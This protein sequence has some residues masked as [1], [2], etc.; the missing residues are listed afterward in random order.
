MPVTSLVWFRNDLRVT[1]HAPLLVAARAGVVV[2]VF[3]ADP[4]VARHPEAS[5]ARTAF[6][7]GCVAALDHE[8][9]ALGGR[10]IRRSGDPLSELMALIR[11]TGASALH[12]HEGIDRL[13][14]RVRD[15]RVHTALTGFGVRCHW[16]PAP[17]S[18]AELMPYP[19]YRAHWQATMQA[20]V[21][22]APA[23][24]VVPANL[25]SDP[26]KPAPAARVPVV[27][28][29]PG[30]RAAWAWLARFADRHA[31]DYHWRL[32]YPAARAT[33]ALGPYLAQGVVSHRQCVQWAHAHLGEA[34]ARDPAR[35]KTLAGF[36]ARLRWGAGFAM[37][38]R[39]LP[40]IELQSIFVGFDNDVDWD[41]E[42]FAR[43]QAGETGFPIV[44]AAARCL[45]GTGG[46]R[47][48]NFRARASL[49]SFLANLLNIDWRHGAVHFMR[50]LLDGD[51]AIDHY[52]WCQ[53]AGVTMGLNKSWTRI[54]KPQQNAIDRMDP[55][56][57]F[58]KTWCP[59]LAHLPPKALGIPPPTPGYPPP[60]LDYARARARRVA[61][62]E[63][64]RR[65]LIAAADIV[66]WITPLPCDLTP[67]GAG[68]GHAV[69]W[70]R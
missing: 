12:A 3:I 39:M 15:A 40:Q 57:T 13:Y 23:R 28:P 9:Q 17:G 59:E 11:A 2:P 47:H 43:W 41:G 19:D 48:L 22:A 36:I 66:D 5:P 70:A 69:A 55:D 18:T 49:A 24:I 68:P 21:V 34:A 33:S 45:R 64:A 56:G 58:I 38:L 4:A 20:P 8:L 52:Q 27:L 46:W 25:V 44:D 30:P 60:M 32:S 35:G 51:C 50:H 6:I 61:E 1:D 63:R 29:Y 37:R 42:A 16:Y 26:P 14:S 31:H 67:F 54:Y 10:L 65:P 62:L 53:A 7:D